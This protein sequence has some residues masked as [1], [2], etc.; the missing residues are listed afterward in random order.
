MPHPKLAPRKQS[1]G[2]ILK[3]EGKMW[4]TNGIRV[5][6]LVVCC[7]VGDVQSEEMLLRGTIVNRTKYR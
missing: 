1:H 4:N 7:S 5:R 6:I 2:P 3:N